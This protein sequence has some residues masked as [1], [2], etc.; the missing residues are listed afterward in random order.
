MY[1]NCTGR[2][3]IHARKLY[4]GIS[5]C[6]EWESYSAFE[7]WAFGHGWQKGMVLTRRNKSMDFSP[8]NCFWA[9]RAEANGW[10]SVVRHLPDGRTIRDVIGRETRGEDKAKHDNISRRVFCDGWELQDALDTPIRDISPHGQ[11]LKTGE[12]APLYNAWRFMRR[13]CKD[14][15]SFFG[16]WDRY[17][18]F[19]EWSI[20]NGWRLGAILHRK[21]TKADFTP[22]NCYWKE[23][24]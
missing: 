5:F 9:T 7:R 4:E 1:R 19:R 12:E 16:G 6:P 24:R 13:T 20:A 23:G 14:G 10:R 18:D 22:E 11:S 2:A 21:D 8:E 15:L 3:P 17:G